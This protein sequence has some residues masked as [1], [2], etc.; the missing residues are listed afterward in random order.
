[1]VSNAKMHFQ[2]KLLKL[3]IYY[4][5]CYEQM[6]LRVPYRRK[7]RARRGR[8][9]NARTAMVKTPYRNR[10]RRRYIPLNLYP[11]SKLVRL[12]YTQ[13]WSIDPAE[14]TVSAI[15]F[16]ANSMFDVSTAT[17]DHQ[18]RGFDQ[19][20]LGY[21]HFTVIGSKISATWI[22]AVA[23]QTV[24]GQTP[25]I[26]GFCTLPTASFSGLSTGTLQISDILESRLRPRWQYAGLLPASG[27][28]PTL[29]TKFS[30][31]KYFRKNAI[32][33]TP[34]YKGNIA[35]DP[36]ELAY[37]GMFAG[38]AVSGGTV[39]PDGQNFMVSIEYIAV[40]TEPKI[41]GPS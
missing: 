36:S 24:E 22:P 25:M 13:T 2:P 3:S 30:A 38:P 40:L 26:W 7:Y 9:K 11:T 41:L 29:T 32:V 27:K 33:G 34:S 16:K 12:R 39:N 4:F 8:R 19:A 14:D 10:Y 28:P 15:Y 21:E 17:G 23:G 5:L 35:S 20:M 1:M 37:F 31:K 18:P 6:P